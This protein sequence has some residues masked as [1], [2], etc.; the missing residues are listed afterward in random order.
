VDITGD[1]GETDARRRPHAKGADDFYVAVATTE[2]DEVLFL[3][4]GW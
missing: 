3:F 4:K 1:E 2:Q